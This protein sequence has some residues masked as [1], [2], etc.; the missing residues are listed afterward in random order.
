MLKDVVGYDLLAALLGSA[1]RLAIIAAVTFRLEPAA[2]R[3]RD[4]EATGRTHL[5]AG[6]RRRVRPE[7]TAAL[8]RSR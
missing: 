3:T 4:C 2:A 5:A 8:G 6:S 7:A 1:G